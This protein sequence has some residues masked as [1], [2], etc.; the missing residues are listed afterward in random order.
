MKKYFN[1]IEYIKRFNQFCGK[2]F[3]IK[4]WDAHLN[5]EKQEK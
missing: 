5:I 2:I 4:T 1:Y 3:K